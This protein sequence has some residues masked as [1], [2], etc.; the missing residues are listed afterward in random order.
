MV[1]PTPVLS[2]HHA[3][4]P[5]AL[6]RLEGERRFGG[7]LS[8]GRARFVQARAGQQLHQPR[9]GRL[10]LDGPRAGFPRRRLILP[11]RDTA[12]DLQARAAEA[13]AHG[14]GAQRQGHRRRPGPAGPAQ[15]LGQ[16]QGFFAGRPGMF[17]DLAQ[18]LAAGGLQCGRLFG[19]ALGLGQAQRLGQADG[20]GGG[21]AG[22][23]AEGEQFQRVE[24]VSRAG[25]RRQAQAP[26][27]QAG[28]G[29]EGAARFHQI[30]RFR[31]PHRSRARAIGDGR[32]GTGQDHQGGGEIE[33]GGQTVGRGGVHV[34]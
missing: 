9:P 18:Q 26:R 22:G 4:L 32:L 3:R 7:E 25:R 12:P 8:L 17:G 6:A 16:G 21:E 14:F 2:Q 5:F 23:A 13:F 10:G 33:G 30:A 27:G 1:L 24:Q 11:F 15:G 28:V 19:G 29:Y 34:G 31:R 20:G